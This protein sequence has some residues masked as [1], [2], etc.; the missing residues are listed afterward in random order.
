MRERSIYRGAAVLGGIAAL[1]LIWL[2]LGVG[3]LG[4][5]GDRA[6]LMY[7]AVVLVGV[8]GSLAVRF[9]ARGMAGVLATMAATQAAIT[10]IALAV[11]VQESGVS[12]TAEIVVLNGF[13]IAM[14]LASAWMFRHAGSTHAGDAHVS[15]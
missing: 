1:L 10:A 2:S 6:N 11:G 8:V 5:D 3:I 12:P 14:F 15:R 13:F 9:D 4:A 7:A